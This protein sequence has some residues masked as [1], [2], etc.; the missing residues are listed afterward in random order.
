MVVAS[1]PPYLRDRRRALV[2]VAALA[3]AIVAL[4]LLAFVAFAGAAM[5]DSSVVDGRLVGPF[6]WGEIEVGDG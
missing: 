4:A 2:L 5:V 6:R 1:S 3:I